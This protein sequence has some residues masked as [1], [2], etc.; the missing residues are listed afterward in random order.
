MKQKRLTFNPFELK[1]S[2]R[3]II[4]VVFSAGFLAIFRCAVLTFSSSAYAFMFFPVIVITIYWGLPAGSISTVVFFLI[5]FFLLS[6]AEYGS[7]GG[8]KLSYIPPLTVFFVGIAGAG[9]LRGR[10]V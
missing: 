6:P 3:L 2:T 4:S 1:I 7:A 8:F 10:S 5:S 9:F